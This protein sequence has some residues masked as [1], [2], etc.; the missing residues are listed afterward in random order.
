MTGWR[1]SWPAHF[2]PNATLCARRSPLAFLYFKI[3]YPAA[4]VTGHHIGP[5]GNRQAPLRIVGRTDLMLAGVRQKMA[6]AKPQPDPGKAS[7][8][9][10]SEKIRWQQLRDLEPCRAIKPF[11]NYRLGGNAPYSKHQACFTD[12]NILQLF[13]RTDIACRH[14][15]ENHENPVSRTKICDYQV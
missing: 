8:N 13:Y 3:Y 11:P 12:T 1:G 4:T 14:Q 9:L 5:T 7:S 2:F 6:V 15:D 10:I